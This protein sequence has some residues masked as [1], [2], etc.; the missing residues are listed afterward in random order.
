MELF[1]EKGCLTNQA[2]IALQEG[3]LD[4][5][6]RLEA[7]EHLAYCDKCIDRYTLLLSGQVLEEPPRPLGRA[8]RQSLWVRVMQS[9]LGRGVVACAAAVLAIGLWNASRALPGLP[10]NGLTLPVRMQSEEQ[11]SC[12]FWESAMHPRDP[13]APAKAALEKIWNTIKTTGGFDHEK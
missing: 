11:E 10:E 13:N 7:A 3:T 6:S 12:E 5:L 1:D 4:E 2:L 9:T 8:V